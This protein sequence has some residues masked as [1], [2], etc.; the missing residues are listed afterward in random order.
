MRRSDR[1]IKDRDQIEAIIEKSEVC[2]LGLC[3]RNEPYV[4]PLN[5]GYKD[6]TIYIHSA[7]EGK[8][9]EILKN[10]S[11]VCLTFNSDFE[12]HIKGKPEEWT[13]YYR[14]VIALGDAE[15]LTDPVQKQK[16]INIIINKYTN[17]NYEFSPEVLDKFKIIR[18][19]LTEITGKGN[20]DDQ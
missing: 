10:N 16:S 19:T 20:G 1:E 12:Q 7:T 11:K 2:F 15:I 3:D 14:S 6:D 5:F 17:R 4:V 9:L 18:I 13:T 8:K